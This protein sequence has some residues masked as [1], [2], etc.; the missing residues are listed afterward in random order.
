MKNDPTLFYLECIACGEQWSE[1]QASTRCVKCWGPLEVLYDYDYIRARLN[2]YSLKTSPLSALKYLDFYPIV[3][4]RDLVS[5][6]EGGTP[7]FELKNL[8]AEL[9]LKR[10]LLK[11]E[12]HNPTGAFKDRGSMVELTKAREHGAKA[13]GVASTGNMAASVSAYAAKAQIPCYVLIPDGVSIGKI[14]QTLAYG[15]R[16]IQVRGTYDDAA[17]LT[18]EMAAKHGFYLAGD[19][20]FRAEGQKSQAFE[21]IEQ[22]FWKSPAVVI[23]PM[24]CGTN[25]ASIWKGFKEFNALGLIDETPQM[26]GVQAAGC[27]PIVEA[28]EAQTETV[29]PVVRPDTAC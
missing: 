16:V 13:I 1:R 17:R 7:L 29:T 27:A 11:D 15:A 8:A 22:L 4:A 25:L 5:L 28:F 18:V 9:G 6:N 14:S 23:V 19:F 20:A 10:L 3:N 12:G 26:V 2:H 21:M 24:G